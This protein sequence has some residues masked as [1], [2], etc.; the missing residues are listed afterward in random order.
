[1][2]TV[3]Q[4]I[5]DAF[6]QSNLV[7]IGQEPNSAQQTEALRYLNRLV[8]SV[9]G[10]EAGDPLTAVP[11]GSVGYARPTDYPYFEPELDGEWFVP[12]NARM[13][14]NLDQSASL[15]LHPAPDDGCRVGVTDV[16][17]S[18]TNYPV[19]L[20]GNGNLIEGVSS[21]AL[22]EA[23]VD[24]E[25]F[26]RADLGDWV[27]CSDLALDTEFPFPEEFDDYFITMLAIRINPSYGSQLDGQSQMVLNRSNKQLRNRYAQ[28]VEMQSDLALLRMSK[29]GQEKNAYMAGST[30]ENARFN[31]G[32]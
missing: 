1:M 30:D 12:K 27:L 20:Y 9:F 2:T 22:N 23:G 11:V 19:T 26:Y 10:N 32:R 15:Y 28:H 13:V 17:Q 25:W 18:L 14:L 8:K 4:L 3:T 7:A 21:I 24:K 5:T 6:R 16:Q 31:R 29:S